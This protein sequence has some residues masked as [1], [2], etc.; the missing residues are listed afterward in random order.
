MRIRVKTQ[1][2]RCSPIQIMPYIIYQR[3]IFQ[4]VVG[5]AHTAVQCPLPNAHEVFACLSA[6]DLQKHSELSCRYTDYASLF[7][8]LWIKY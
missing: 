4:I 7:S 3:Y 6:Q 2:S 1:A 5:M 8:A